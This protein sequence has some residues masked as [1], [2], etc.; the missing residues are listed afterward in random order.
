MA[1]AVLQALLRGPVGFCAAFH[2]AWIVGKMQAEPPDFGLQCR[3]KFHD[4]RSGFLVAVGG[5]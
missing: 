5:K 3:L 4:Q 2:H 1:E